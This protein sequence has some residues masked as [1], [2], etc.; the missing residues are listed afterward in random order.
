MQALS[1][2]LEPD[3]A[4]LSAD[5]LD[6]LG[7]AA[8]SFL[9]EQRILV[10]AENAAHVVCDACHED[11]VERVERV[12]G[13]DREVRFQV[14]CRHAGL[15][16][17]AAERVRQWRVDPGRMAD[18]L[19]DCL[20]AR[21][22]TDNVVPNIAWW[23]GT[24]EIGDA[25]YSVYF[26]RNGSRDVTSAIAR[27]GQ[28][29]ARLRTIVVGLRALAEDADGFALTTDIASAFSWDGESFR[30][31]LNRLRSSLPV[32]VYEGNVFILEGGSYRITYEGK[33]ITL[34][35]SAGLFYIVCLMQNRPNSI[36]SVE[37]QALRNDE[38]PL[39][40]AGTSGEAIGQEGLSILQQRL[41]D[42]DEE[43]AESQNNHDEARL[44]QLQAEREQILAEVRKATGLGGR[45]RVNSD[46]EKA[47][48][49]VLNAITGA[50]KKISKSHPALGEHLDKTI[51]TG[52]HCCYPK[53]V[54]WLV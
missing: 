21:Q 45:L 4:V 42:L 20:T 24:V 49:A 40:L 7:E 39:V 5:D 31:Q 14:Y 46:A 9:V 19:A 47:R 3:R 50:I 38:S 27:I 10:L 11:H 1:R 54:E 34:P 22:K 12:V 36:S 2:L 33:Q 32:D 44:E 26:V 53:S 30:L 8:R 51:E 43:I 48:K 25:A 17:V 37:L 29:G 6:D 41:D 35:S 23:L 52:T 15:V 18:L 28:R 13:R 16:D